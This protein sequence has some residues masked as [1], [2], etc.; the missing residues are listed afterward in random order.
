MRWSDLPCRIGGDEFAVVLVDIQGKAAAVGRAREIFSTVSALAVELGGTAVHVRSS[1]GGALLRPGEALDGL[2]R[3]ADDALYAAKARGR[4]SLVW[5]GEPIAF[6]GRLTWTWTW[7]WT[8]TWTSNRD[9]GPQRKPAPTCLLSI[10][11]GRCP[12]PV[13]V[14]VQ[15]QVRW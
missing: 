11:L 9:A 6:L 13:Q 14:Q 8:L 3:R 1:H 15:V 4:G 5:E 7:T 10:D 12:R 2:L